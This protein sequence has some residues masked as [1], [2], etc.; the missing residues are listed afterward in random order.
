MDPLA[1]LFGSF[2]RLKLL[3]LF[4]FND[5]T[6]FGVADMAFRTKTPKDQVRKE[7]T[8]LLASEVIRKRT[9]KGTAAYIANKRFTHYEALTA[10][11]RATTDLNDADIVSILKKAGAL[12]LVAM[13][14]LFTG[15]IETKIDL[16]IVGDNLDDKH[17]ESAVHSLEAHFG[18]ELS[19]AA[20]TTQDFRYRV[21]VYDRLIRDVFDYPHRTILDKIGIRA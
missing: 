20:F 8:Q 3:R 18:R 17:L 4:L 6:A 7:I 21:G 12:R 1:R 2:A 15:A 19:Y 11:M 14:G 16:L 13:S 5:D 10:F 9:G